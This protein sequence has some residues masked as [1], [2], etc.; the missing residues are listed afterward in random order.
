[1]A[2]D[3]LLMTPGP[4]QIPDEVLRAHALPMIH[5]RTAA[6][7]TI[8]VKTLLQLKSVFQT[9][10]P[11][12]I[13]TSTGSGGME[14]AIVNTL[15]PGDEVLVVV[16]GKFGERWAEMCTTFGAKVH[17]INVPWGEA[18][19]PT[20]V[21]KTLPNH[22][23]I[24]AVFCRACGTSTAVLHP[25][26]EIAQIVRNHK[27]TIFIVD[28]ITALGVTDLAMDA[29]GLDVV[30]AGSQKT[31]M[32]P[33]GLSFIAF[34]QKAMRFV[35]EAKM[36]RYYFD[37]RTELKSNAGGF[38]SFSAPVSMIRALS[39]A[40]EIILSKGLKNQ[41]SE[42]EHLSRGLRAGGEA[43]G[44]KSFAKSPSP[45]VTA[46]LTPGGLNSEK[47]RVHLE[48]KYNLTVMG[49]QEQLKGKVIR[50]GTLGAVSAEHVRATL[51][52]LQLGLLDFG[53]SSDI[54]RALKEFD[55]AY[56][57]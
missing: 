29:W 10:E 1:M 15:S 2:F 6:F 11:V 40:L 36:P 14:S 31:F 38:S 47:F 3:Y 57:S 25:I 30:V 52:R 43:L 18:V 24:R 53:I 35:E 20:E 27:D 44:F 7:E 55:G 9:A 46:L 51:A 16:S 13:H 37:V 21:E 34:S 33:T 17:A 26:K 28:A 50:I 48:E 8:F 39:V 4:V 22:S 42:F 45:S 54:N 32:L 23:R 41:I 56:G 5:H 49:G 19:Q 12:L